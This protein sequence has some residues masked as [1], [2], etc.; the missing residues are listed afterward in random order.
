MHQIVGT[1]HPNLW[2]KCYTDVLYYTYIV[3]TVVDSSVWH[4]VKI[5]KHDLRKLNIK[6]IGNY[7]FN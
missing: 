1:R 7:K 4:Y 6:G 2:L 5:V 3:F